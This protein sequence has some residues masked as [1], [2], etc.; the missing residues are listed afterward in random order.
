MFYFSKMKKE[1]LVVGVVLCC[2][3][4]YKYVREGT[5]SVVVRVASW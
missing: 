3:V 1:D 4:G 2:V 5:T